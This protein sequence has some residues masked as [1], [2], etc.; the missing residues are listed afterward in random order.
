[1]RLI[2]VEAVRQN[3]AVFVFDAGSAPEESVFSCGVQFIV[4]EV[5]PIEPRSVVVL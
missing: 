3:R 2:E 5:S 1:L 4:Q